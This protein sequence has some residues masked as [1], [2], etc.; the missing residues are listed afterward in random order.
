WYVATRLLTR[1]GVADAREPQELYALAVHDA[2]P[3]WSS[4]TMAATTC[5]WPPTPTSAWRATSTTCFASTT[6]TARSILRPT[7]RSS[8]PRR[9]EEHTSELQSR[10]NL[11]WRLLLEKQKRRP[12]Q[13]LSH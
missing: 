8:T 5:R 4:P 10:E 9:S 2:L 7:A 3:I 1:I 12:L 6:G 11:V 13:I